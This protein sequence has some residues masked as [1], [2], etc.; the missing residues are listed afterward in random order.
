MLRKSLAARPT[1]EGRYLLGLCLVEQYRA[2]E[3]MPLLKAAVTQRPDRHAWLATLARAMFLERRCAAAMEALAKA[4]ALAPLPAYRYDRA[5]CALNVGDLEA[6]RTEI[7]AILAVSPRDAQALHQLGRIHARVGLTAEA[8]RRLQEAVAAGGSGPDLRF[9]LGRALAEAGRPADALPELD[10][11]IALVPG[12]AGALYQRA[13]VLARLGRREESDTAMAAFRNASAVQERVENLA[14]HVQGHAADV[15]AR[16]ELARDL[17]SLG[18]MDEATEALHAARAVAPDDPRVYAA[19]EALYRRRGME[20]EAARA[21]GR[22][23]AL[24]RA[25]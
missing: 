7:E 22:L 3:A 9:E 14:Q 23:E 17:G 13:R 15:A 5:M 24:E 4:I 2:A 6:A 11:A 10:R 1:P 20:A 12:H 21:A 18:R 8:C 19:L 16:L 25:R